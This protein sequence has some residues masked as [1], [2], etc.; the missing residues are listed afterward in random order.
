[1]DSV[2]LALARLSCRCGDG[3]FK[4]ARINEFFVDRALSASRGTVNDKEQPSFNASRSSSPSSSSSGSNRPS[5]LPEIV[6][7]ASAD[8][9]TWSLSVIITERVRL[10]Q[11]TSIRPPASFCSATRRF[12]G[13]DSGLTTATTL[14]AA[15]IL[16][17]P[18]FINFIISFLPSFSRLFYI[19]YLFADFFKLRLYFNDELCN[20]GIVRL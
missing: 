7:A 18:I 5:S 12:I 11:E 15:T 6:S 3:E 9:M 16:P 1:M 17:K 4:S 13:A 14:C 10:P 2:N 8:K 19:L 20:F